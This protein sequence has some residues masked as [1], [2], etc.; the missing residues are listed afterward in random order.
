VG[1]ADLEETHRPRRGL[2]GE[3]IARRWPAARATGIAINYSG[4]NGLRED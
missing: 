1:A 4:N 2:T 3:Q